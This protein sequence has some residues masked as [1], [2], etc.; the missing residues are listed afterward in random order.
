MADD[1][2]MKQPREH[3]PS[4]GV[5][6]GYDHA[7]RR[8]VV[9]EDPQCPYCAKFERANADLLRQELKAGTLAVEY[10]MRAMLGPESV[11]AC[12]ALALA[13]ESRHF[14]D[15]RADLFAHQPEEQTGG[16]TTEDL[17][18]AGQRAGITDDDFA[19]G[20]RE[21]RYEAWVRGAESQFQTEDPDGTPVLY[22]DGQRVADA[23]VYS[24]EELSTLLKS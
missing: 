3:T 8:L 6:E 12:N 24:P 23:A 14:D 15:L 21:G 9:Y 11:R 2:T 7:R 5:L 13:A 22:L 17:L 4:G 18:A 19:H 20:V 16:F 10:R 1:N